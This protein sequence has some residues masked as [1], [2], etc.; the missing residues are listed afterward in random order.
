MPRT[1][2]HDWHPG[3]IPDN[4][5][6]EDDAYVETSQ[7]F[8]LFRSEHP[9]GLRVE[10]G[11]SIYPPTMLD[12]GPAASMTLG[13]FAMLNGPRII[14]DGHLS[15]GP[16]ALVSWNVVIMDTWRVPFD[17]AARRDVL[18]RA[19]G[20]PPAKRLLAGP[21]EVKPIMIGAN[22]WIGFDAVIL[23]GASIGEGSI[24][25]ARSLVAGVIPPYTIAAGSPARVV[26]SLPR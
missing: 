2:P 17:A 9:H 14:C 13:A 26:K 25:G 7:S 24:I 4:V 1:I 3:V 22:V 15:I 16:H 11:A 19:A 18:R 10:R 23:P 12:L 20:A 21:G 5:L 8:E 6:L